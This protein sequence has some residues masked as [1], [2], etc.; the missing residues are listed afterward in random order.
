MV[1][2]HQAMLLLLA[3]LVAVAGCQQLPPPPELTEDEVLSAPE[4]LIAPLDR[5]QIYVWR[6]PDLSVTVPVRL[7]GRIILPLVEDMQAAG[8]TPA[9][10]ARDIEEAIRPYVQ[11]PRATVV[12][13]GL[14]NE[15]GQMMMAIGEVAKPV[16]VHYQIHMSVLVGM[17]QAQ[18]FSEHADGNNAKLIRKSGGEEQ[19]HRRR[20]KGLLTDGDMSANGKVRPR[21]LIVVPKSSI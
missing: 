7:D 13:E 8:K 2:H 5:V 15:A 16:T 20:L 11:E 1:R 12:V 6:V 10:L 18:G 9:T 14:A 21:D 3:I 19:S 17:A 4:Y